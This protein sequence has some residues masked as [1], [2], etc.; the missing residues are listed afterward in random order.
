MIKQFT[1]TLDKNM[2]KKI[3]QILNLHDSDKKDKS[4]SNSEKTKKK[5]FSIKYGINNVTNSIKQKKAIFVLIAH[6]VNPIELVAWL[7]TL[8]YTMDIPY[9]IIK[10][11][12]KLGN[13]VNKK[14]T[15]CVAITCVMNK[16]REEIENIIKYF[17]KNFNSK[18]K[19]FKKN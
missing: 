5:V 3:L 9:S 2:T 18:Y 10:N 13:I 17:R 7:P 6:D 15:S 11:K 1:S 19:Q 16:N 8:C 14:T 12:S 4:I